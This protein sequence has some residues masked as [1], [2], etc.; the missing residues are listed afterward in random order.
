MRASP[1]KAG[2]ALGLLLALYHAGWACLVALGWAQPLLDF[3]LW[4]HFLKVPVTIE[5]FDSHQASLLVGATGLAGWLMGAVLAA[6]WNLL[7]P[8]KA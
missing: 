5:P 6:L 7:H 3:I 4:A 2:I 8:K 1:L